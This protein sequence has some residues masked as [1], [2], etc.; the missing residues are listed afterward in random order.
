M[1]DKK[2]FLKNLGAFASED[3]VLIIVIYVRIRTHTDQ[4]PIHQVGEGGRGGG[5]RGC[6]HQHLTTITCGAVC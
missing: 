5:W 2:V 3:G 1:Q 6:V 4:L